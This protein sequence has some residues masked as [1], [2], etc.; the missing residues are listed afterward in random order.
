LEHVLW[1]A[2][3]TGL[4]GEVDLPLPNI[5]AFDRLYEEGDSNRLD[6]LVDWLEHQSTCAYI[7]RHHGSDGLQRVLRGVAKACS[8]HR[9][10]MGSRV[11]SAA[12]VLGLQV[13]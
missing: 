5:S 3:P 13:Y 11:A 4:P 2:G 10:H 8:V 7:M 9:C 6:W 12:G 1:S